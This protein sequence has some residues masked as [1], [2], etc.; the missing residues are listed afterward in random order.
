M[1]K[2]YARYMYENK[3]VYSMFSDGGKWSWDNGRQQNAYMRQDGTPVQAETAAQYA[4]AHYRNFG[5]REGRQLHDAGGTD[6][7][8]LL[9]GGG[10]GAPTPSPPPTPSPQNNSMAAL[11]KQVADL[12][13]SLANPDNKGPYTG[14]EKPDLPMADPLKS[15][16]LF[17]NIDDQKKKK[18]FLTPFG[19]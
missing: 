5:Q 12:T 6:Y 17:G 18:S 4:Q 8:A 9:R 11:Q 3:D 1:A 15:T 13:M 19:A 2:D 7:A 14:A 10:G 16:I